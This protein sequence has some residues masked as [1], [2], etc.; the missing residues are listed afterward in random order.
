MLLKQELAD[1]FKNYRK[2]VILGI[3]N[4]ILGDDGLG[5]FI[6]RSLMDLDE[7]IISLD[8]GVV[9]ENFT[10]TIKKENA[11]HILLVDAVELG[12]APGYVR[13]VEKDEIANYSISTHSIPISF[14]IKYLQV[15]TDAKIALIGIQ[16]ESME[17]GDEISPSVKK[18]AIEVLNTLKYIL[19]IEN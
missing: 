16:P 5:S 18:S 4:D 8:G 7:Y 19:N 9:P 11:S 2:V 17:L 12:E 14:L 13:L 1:F 6:A 3:G 15:G 10:G